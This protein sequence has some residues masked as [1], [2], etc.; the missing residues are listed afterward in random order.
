MTT[1]PKRP[2]AYEQLLRR[3]RQLDDAALTRPLTAGEA[4][5]VARLSAQMEPF[6][7]EMDLPEVT[8]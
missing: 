3:W 7:Q 2:P 1:K 4:A 6:E 5:E 8:A